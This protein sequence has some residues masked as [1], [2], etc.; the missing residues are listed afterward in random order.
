MSEK[1]KDRFVMVIFGG[2]GDLSKRKLIPAL[3][4]LSSMGYLPDKYAILAESRGSLTDDNYREW[5]RNALP[6]EKPDAFLPFVFYQTGDITKPESFTALKARLDKLDKD[7][8]LGG[9]RLFYLA[10]APELV[11]G[12][13]E[14]LH[15]CRLLHANKKSWVRVVFEK[16]FGHDLQSARALNGEIKR[17][18]HENQIFRIDHYLGKETVQNILTFRF[19]NSIFEPVFNRTHINNIRITVAESIGMEGRRGAYYDTAGALRDI[20]QNHALQLLCLTTMEPPATFDAEAIRDEK[21]KVLRTLPV[22]TPQQVASNTVR[23]QY[24][25]YRQEEGVKADSVTET[26]VAVRTTI[27]NWRWSGV[28]IV[29]QTGKK[30][31]ARLTEIEIEFNQPPLCIFREFADCPPNPN[32]LVIRIQPNEGISLSFVCKQPGPTFAVQDVKMDFSYDTAFKQR[33]PEAYER[34]LLDALRGDPSLFTR[35]DEVEAA[36]RFITAILEGWSKL[37][38]PQYPNQEPGAYPADANRLLMPTQ[39]RRQ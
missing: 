30:L 1:I 12:I 37:P 38:P 4:S 14:R 18:L 29:I 23:G 32:S 17:L 25:G 21:V 36:W 16:P 24:K 22:M 20:V 35:S 6:D 31:P 33:S 11:Q 5:V 27:D 26:Y 7:L 2:T 19:G 8:E 15:E 13:V 3:Y 39:S 9:N 28:P 10:V 34:L